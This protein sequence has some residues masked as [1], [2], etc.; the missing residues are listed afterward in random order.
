MCCFSIGFVFCIVQF[1]L[2]R[3]MN[4]LSASSRSSMV[5]WNKIA[6]QARN[7][8]PFKLHNPSQDTPWVLRL[9][10]FYEVR[11][12][13][14]RGWDH[15]KRLPPLVLVTSWGESFIRIMECGGGGRMKGEGVEAEVWG[16]PLH[17]WSALSSPRWTRRRKPARRIQIELIAILINDNDY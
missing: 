8:N 1:F 4:V 9:I 15:P 5:A 11:I 2:P 3:V 17:R 6:C 14:K 16:L 13:E 12:V 10:W 7:K